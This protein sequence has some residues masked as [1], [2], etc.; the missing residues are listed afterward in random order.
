MN[1]SLFLDDIRFPN[2]VKYSYGPY[3]ELVICRSMN[4]AVW[5]VRNYGLPNF[6]SFDHDL[7]DVHNDWEEQTGLSF[8]HWLADYIMNNDVKYDPEFSWFIHSANPVGAE[9]INSYMLSLKNH[10]ETNYS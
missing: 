3:K 8:A 6:I 2:D 10:W 5:A 9:N 7:G 1:W 4:D